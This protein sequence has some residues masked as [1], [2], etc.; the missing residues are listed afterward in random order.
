[1]TEGHSTQQLSPGQQA[2]ENPELDGHQLPWHKMPVF[3][4]P[5]IRLSLVSRLQD[6]SK[7]ELLN[8]AAVPNK[9]FIASCLFLLQTAYFAQ[10]RGD[11]F[12]CWLG[13]ARLGLAGGGVAAW[14]NGGWVSGTSVVKATKEIGEENSVGMF[15]PPPY[16][17]DL[18]SLNMSPVLLVVS[19]QH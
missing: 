6:L 5:Q 9:L 1:M 12:Y 7:S 8:H 13:V 14:V 19:C 3:D 17:K 11:P 15:F 16:S 18:G 2:A 4:P 10:H